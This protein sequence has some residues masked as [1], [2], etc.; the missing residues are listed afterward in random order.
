MNIVNGTF[1]GEI[2]SGRDYYSSI[3]S[4][5]TNRPDTLIDEIEKAIKELKETGIGEEDFTITKNSIY[6]SMIMSFENVEEVATE[7]VNAHFKGGNLYTAMDT[8]AALTLDDVNSQLKNMMRD[9]KKSVF[10]VLPLEDV[11]D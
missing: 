9:D 2:F 1:E 5:E 4:G 11:N 3:I 8:L 6:G 10:K 7:M